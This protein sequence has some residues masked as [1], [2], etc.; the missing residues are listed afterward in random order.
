VPDLRGKRRRGTELTQQSTRA[1]GLPDALKTPTKPTAPAGCE[2]SP[3]DDR[4][5]TPLGDS[6][7]EEQYTTKNREEIM[8]VRNPACDLSTY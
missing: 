2:A 4:A 7:T 6:Q 3:S 8:V 1:D 5:K